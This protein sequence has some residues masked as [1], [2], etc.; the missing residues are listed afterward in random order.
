MVLNLLTLL[1][2]AYALFCFNT[3]V[4]SP[5]AFRAWWLFIFA[6]FVCFSLLF[7]TSIVIVIKARIMAIGIPWFTLL[8]D[9]HFGICGSIIWFFRGSEELASALRGLR[10]NWMALW[11]TLREGGT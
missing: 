1:S 7:I 11:E 10:R 9:V 4:L 3:N 8:F 6:V 2:F 5:E